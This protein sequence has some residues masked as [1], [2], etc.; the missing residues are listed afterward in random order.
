MHLV[1]PTSFVC[2]IGFI[3]QGYRNT[4]D[5]VLLGWMV[6]FAYKEFGNHEIAVSS[7]FATSTTPS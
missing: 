7:N 5:R 2:N 1:P 4:L 6:I 3:M